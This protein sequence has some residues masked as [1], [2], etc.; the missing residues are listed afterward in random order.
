M[1]QNPSL[2]TRIAIGKVIGLAF[3]V[4]GVLL[5]LQFWPDAD[6]MILWGVLLWYP[7]LG[8]IIGVFGVFTS[9]PVLKLPLPWWLRAPLSGG[10]MNLVL[11]LFAYDMFAII[12][13]DVFGSD[14][15]LTSPFWFV[16]EGA[17]IGLVIGYLATKFGGEGRDTVTALE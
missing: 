11:T 13:A 10:W 12:T 4:A 3:G 5:L 14:S 1:I 15:P 9:H 2:V 7:T 6:W 8:A 16:L 17:L